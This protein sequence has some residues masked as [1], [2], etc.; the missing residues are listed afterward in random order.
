MRIGLL[1]HQQ[2]FTEFVNGTWR[3]WYIYNNDV[4]SGSYYQLFSDGTCDRVSV[5]DGDIVAIDRVA[6]GSVDR[7]KE[8]EEEHRW[9]CTASL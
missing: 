5:V 8:Q 3:I 9:R 7:L 2:P 1:R 6:T 4:T